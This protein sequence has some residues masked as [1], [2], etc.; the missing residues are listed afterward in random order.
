MIRAVMVVG[1]P[2]HS[3]VLHVC[4]FPSYINKDKETI[5]IHST[6]LSDDWC[7]LY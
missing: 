3:M 2:M 5:L 1:S 6:V 7:H 4:L